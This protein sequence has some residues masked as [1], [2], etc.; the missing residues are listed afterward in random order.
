ML[1]PPEQG[2]PAENRLIDLIL[3]ASYVTLA[4]LSMLLVLSIFSWA[5]IFLKSRAY[6]RVRKANRQFLGEFRKG[7]TPA[8]LNKAALRQKD[9]P[10]AALY[11]GC[12]KRLQKKGILS[13]TFQFESSSDPG[14]RPSGKD[15]LPLL[16]AIKNDEM[17]SLESFL[18]YFAIIGNVSPFIGLFGTVLGII[19]AFQ[20]I[21]Q[22][23][24][25]NI[26]AVAPGIAEALVATAA[27]LFTAIPAV[28][29]Y[30]YFLKRLRGID[31]ELDRFSEELV[32]FIDDQSGVRAGAKGAIR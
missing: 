21:S 15:L 19:D 29:A 3:T 32:S 31:A 23:G 13:D 10:A 12:V 4:V 5:G 26:A 2:F 8:A 25:A 11:L 1:L 9:S 30:N 22:V 28:I 20:N 24:S 17:I 14:N 16:A 18:S 27:G 7:E 6:S